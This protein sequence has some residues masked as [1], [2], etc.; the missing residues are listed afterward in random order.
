M[1]GP[2]RWQREVGPWIHDGAFID[3]RRSTDDFLVSWGLRELA[4]WL[5]SKLD[6]HDLRKD[7]LRRHNEKPMEFLF[8]I[9][10]GVVTIAEKQ[11]FSPEQVPVWRPPMY[12]QFLQEVVTCF[13]LKVNVDLLINVADGNISVENVPTFSF[14]KPH[15]SNTI[16]IPDV[17][18]LHF[19][20]YY[21]DPKY[22]DSMHF[23]RKD[24]SAV[25][26]GATT[27]APLTRDNVIQGRHPRIRSAMFFRAMPNVDFRLP[28]LTTNDRQLC[29][30]LKAMGLG[31]GNKLSYQDQFRH[32]FIISMDGWGATCSRIP[33]VLRSNSVLLKYDS[34]HQLYYFDAMVPWHHY[35]PIQRDS[36]VLRA[37]EMS[38]EYP[39]AFHSITRRAKQFANRFLTKSQVMRY[40]AH[41]LMAYETLFVAGPNSCLSS[42]AYDD[43]AFNSKVSAEPSNQEIA[44]SRPCVTVVAHFSKIGDR[45]FPP[46]VN[47]EAGDRYPIEGFAIEPCAEMSPYEIEYRGVLPNGNLTAAVTA[48]MYVGTK[49]Q[50][51]PLI[52][53]S[54]RTTGRLADQW[55]CLYT[56]CF[57]DGSRA[58]S[59]TNGSPCVSA[60]G[61]PL[62][63]FSVEFVRTEA[64]TN[65]RA[66]V[67]FGNSPTIDDQEGLRALMMR[68]ESL[69]GW[70]HGCEFGLVQR[71]FHAEPLGLL[72][73]ADIGYE[74]LLTALRTE[75]AGVGDES[76]T[77]IFVP[78]AEA[79]E[80]WTLDRRYHM[81]MRTFV[82]TADAT[83][84][85]MKGRVERRLKFLKNKLIADLRAGEKWFVYKDMRRTLSQEELSHLAD[86]MKQYG[87]SKLV[88]VARA[89]A[90]H[91]HSTVIDAAPNLLIAFIDRFAFTPEDKFA[92][93]SIDLFLDV[94]REIASRME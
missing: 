11:P 76:N 73:W 8:T 68:F 30:E 21:G 92:G 60:T 79:D 7:L 32:Q 64:P 91:P 45:R 94:C 72:R 52:G 13:D 16:L 58:K 86:A 67:G 5:S 85:Q 2:G 42:W 28:T 35:I 81:A 48:G 26:V 53:A 93:S 89:D 70:G 61:S 50:A 62:V 43:A 59:T 71:H 47:V 22:F 24:R 9:A 51:T 38:A 25:F 83:I 77:V 1:C 17:D 80:Y 87:D 4:P 27:G 46:N 88:Y 55:R 14:Q 69:G 57:A 34:P 6:R 39:D 37:V 10:N 18:F 63:A 33:I 66:I 90:D 40:T 84:E 75:F 49:G 65:K 15:G 19:N 23:A 20:Y 82:R 31:L 56:C 54:F 12:Q 3:A 74:Q 36:D 44:P 41:L 78:D 29:D